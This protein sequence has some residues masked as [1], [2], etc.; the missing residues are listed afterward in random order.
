MAGS[1][2]SRT[3]RAPVIGLAPD[4]ADDEQRPLEQQ[5]HHAGEDQ[6]RDRV[7]TGRQDDREEHDRE[8]RPA[9][10]RGQPAVA[11]DPDPR[12]ADEHDRELEDQAEGQHHRGHEADVALDRQVRDGEALGEVE[13]EAQRV[14]DDE[15]A[16]HHAEHEERHRDQDHRPDEASLA[17]GEARRHEAPQLEQDHRHG[18]RDAQESGDLQL[19]GEGVRRA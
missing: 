16:D 8:D 9:A 19:S 12:Q 1:V 15:V 7:A 18:D 4:H 13:Q 3:R 14:R 10:L 6:R 11:Q 5:E 2:R 17:L